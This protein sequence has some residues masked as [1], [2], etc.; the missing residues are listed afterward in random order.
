MRRRAST[1]PTFPDSKVTAVHKTP[2]DFSGGKQG[3]VLTVDFTVSRHSLSRHQ[4]R[5]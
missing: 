2:S 1:P 4:R 5:P 3:D